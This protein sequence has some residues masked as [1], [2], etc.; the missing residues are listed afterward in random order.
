MGNACIDW[1]IKYTEIVQN[2]FRMVHLYIAFNM[3][4]A[5]NTGSWCGLGSD[6]VLSKYETLSQTFSLV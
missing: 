5:C 2:T 4:S 6:W 1:H 3:N